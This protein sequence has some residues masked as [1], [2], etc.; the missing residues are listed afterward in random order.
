VNRPP[1]ST[2]LAPAR[3][4]HFDRASARHRR[5]HRRAPQAYTFSDPAWAASDFATGFP[6]SNASSGFGPTGVAEPLRGSGLGR[7]L[8]RASLADLREL[9]YSRVVIPWTD[10]IDFYRKSCGA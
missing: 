5:G 9:G 10:A 3:I 2:F 1:R 4:P 8:L 7:D 6:S